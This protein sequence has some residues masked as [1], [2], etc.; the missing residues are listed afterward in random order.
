MDIIYNCYGYIYFSTSNRPTVFLLS[1][2]LCNLN[3]NT[4]IITPTPTTTTTY[5]V[6]YY[7][8]IVVI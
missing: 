4:I 7:I 6:A 2:Q 3:N 1:K 5:Y 8:F